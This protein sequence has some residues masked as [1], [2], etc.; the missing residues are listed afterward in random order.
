M[1]ALNGVC[2]AVAVVHQQRVVDTVQLLSA[3]MLDG[4]LSCVSC[5][6][7]SPLQRYAEYAAAIRQEYSH[8]SDAD[9]CAGRCAG[10]TAPRLL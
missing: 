3:E 2:P 4:Q 1:C 6:Q 9:Y 7:G 5:L 8:L 10:Y